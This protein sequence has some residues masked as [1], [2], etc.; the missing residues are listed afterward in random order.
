MAHLFKLMELD[1]L[2]EHCA[3]GDGL[4]GFV[5]NVSLL[6]LGGHDMPYSFVQKVYR[7]IET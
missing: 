3:G 1:S 4:L 2:P 5:R 6:G 7:L